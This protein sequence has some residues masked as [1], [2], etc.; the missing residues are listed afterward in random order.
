MGT[1]EVQKV[2]GIKFNNYKKEE[3]QLMLFLR[4]RK[5][6]KIPSG[7]SIVYG[8]N[9]SGKTTIS[10]AISNCVNNTP[11]QSTKFINEDGK[12]LNDEIENLDNVFIFNEDFIN[13]N[14]LI[15]DDGIK[16]IVLIG[17][18]IN[19][20]AKLEENEQKLEEYRRK[21]R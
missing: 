8:A 16:T 5:G 18:D 4:E 21:K 2:A 3:Q 14:I 1:L 17:E 9:G 15:K 6:K 12:A 11:G 19:L 10:R 13:N 20:S 7:I